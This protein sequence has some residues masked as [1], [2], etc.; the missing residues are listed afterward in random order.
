MG[1]DHQ[2]AMVGIELALLD[3]SDEVGQLY[4][5]LACVTQNC[6]LPNYYLGVYMTVVE[7]EP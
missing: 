4:Q 7:G 3:Y 6:D 2:D 1:Q 5:H